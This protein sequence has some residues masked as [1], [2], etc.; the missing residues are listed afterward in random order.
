[1]HWS[2]AA[3]DKAATRRDLPTLD[4][5]LQT[6]REAA[7][8]LPDG[9]GLQSRAR[10][11]LLAAERLVIIADYP[12]AARA[13]AAAANLAEQAGMAAVVAKARL[14]E[15][16]I[17]TWAG[18]ESLE[19]FDRV[20]E[21]A[22]DAC[23]KA[24]DIA[25]EIET[26]HVATNH[27]WAVGRLDEYIETNE[28]LVAQARSIGDSA[29]AAAILVRLAPA[30]GMRG[31][32]QAAERHLAE[33]ESLAEILGFRN[34]GLGALM[35]RAGRFTI[36]GDLAAS[37]RTHREFL[38]AAEDAGAVQYQVSA[39]R[40]LA[41]DLLYLHRAGEAAMALDR[42]LELSETSG[43]R[44]NRSELWGQRAL[45]ALLLG[46]LEAA[47]SFISRAVSSLREE[48]VTAIAEVYNYLGMIRS[49]Q[50]RES[51]AEAAQRQSL[52]AVAQTDYNWVK[53]E[54]TLAL[55]TLLAKR[56][57]L[58]EAKA[59]FEERERWVH[60]QKIHLWDSELS[61]IRSLIAAKSN[62]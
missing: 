52:A 10:Q 1:L 39:L 9:G 16:W 61:E 5:A 20:V 19:E 23:R 56:G 58:E 43:E 6:A 7:A 25:G 38:V 45:A 42:A 33:A 57:A 47:E 22:V 13:T 60:E 31:N 3:G 51:E 35:Q 15:A 40:H 44:W 49:A 11:S 12:A 8:R 21:R 4:A 30:E 14:G 34:I 50:G 26:R 36:M 32:Q 29:H 41:R 46:D 17:A 48:D 18:T 37:E 24:G 2:L 54:P 59:L 62:A 28:R 27:L 53:V 55:T